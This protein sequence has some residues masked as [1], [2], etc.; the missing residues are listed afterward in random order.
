MDDAQKFTD[1]VRLPYEDGEIIHSGR[2][3]DVSDNTE[4]NMFDVGRSGVRNYRAATLTFVKN[5]LA[6]SKLFIQ[7]PEADLDIRIRDSFDARSAATPGYEMVVE[8]RN[9]TTPTYQSDIR[10]EPAEDYDKVAR[11][12]E[13][14]QLKSSLA[15]AFQIGMRHGLPKPPEGMMAILPSLHAPL[16]NA[17]QV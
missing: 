13:A 17:S 4:L 6:T 11:F 9:V 15:V 16:S 3:I 12:S 5:S 14:R 8:M 10:G 1:I 7:W 2:R